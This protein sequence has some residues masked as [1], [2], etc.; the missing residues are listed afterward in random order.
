MD[1][2]N[3]RIAL[4][5]ALLAV[6]W[7]VVDAV[8]AR[9]THLRVLPALLAYP[10]LALAVSLLVLIRERLA[11]RAEEEKQEAALLERERTSASIF[12]RETAPEL[13]TVARTRQQFERFFV[14]AIA[15][16]LAMGLA[17]VT[18]WLYRHLNL[19]ATPPAHRLMTLA[20]LGGQAFT[21]FLLS[22]YLL[23][24]GRLLRGAGIALGVA[25]IASLMAGAATL[26][27]EA[28]FPA[29]DRWAAVILTGFLVVLAAENLLNFIA[30]LYR[31]RRGEPCRSYESRLGELLIAPGAW[32]R[33]VAG[34]LDYQFGF[35]VSETWLFRFLEGAL[36]PLVIFQIVAL[37][38]L[39][40][41]VFL[42]PD[43]RGILE[44]FGK[45]V[46]HLDSGFHL[47]APWPFEVVQ[48]FP[49][50]RVLNFRIG[51]PQSTGVEPAVIQW[52]IPHAEGEDQFLVAAP[53]VGEG[54]VPVNLVAFNIPVEYQITNVMAFAYHNADAGR[55]IEQIAYRS[56]TFEAATHDL[57]EIMGPG[58]ARIAE[59]LRQRIQAEADRRQLGVHIVFVGLQGVHPPTQVAEAFQ[60]VIGALEQKEATVLAARAQ[61]GKTVTLAGA[62][63]SKANLEATAYRTQRAEISAAE[64]KRFLIQAE[65]AK[66][67]P[68]VFRTSLYL[69]T[70]ARALT[71]TRKFIVPASASNEVYQ[72]NFEEKLRPE[73]FDLG[74]KK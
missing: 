43:E 34:A 32:A 53:R 17:A 24:L 46:T 47:K 64:A 30:E 38:L 12:D 25:C 65:T 67:S 49:A 66:K 15:L 8:L 73:L 59:S 10:A 56:L 7:L 16:L 5:A 48:R 3:E 23:G 58:Q 72:L 6:A 35:K 44:R 69:D 50:K 71:D 20:A 55:L 14:P 45:P 63:A 33:N 29:A 22:R 51:Q 57:F 74:A 36:L 4:L 19:P 62:E 11:R 61:A 42:G 41:L 27:G 52:N 9:A 39:S 26:A 31:P 40:C 60:S 68:Q 13:F 18:W 21:M 54:S 37:Y 70:V 28:G 1:K 2:R